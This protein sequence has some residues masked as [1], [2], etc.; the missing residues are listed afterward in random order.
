MAEK[1]KKEYLLNVLR[2]YNIKELEP[3]QYNTLRKKSLDTGSVFFGFKEE[4]EADINIVVHPDNYAQCHHLIES[5]YGRSPIVDDP[6]WKD[7]YNNPKFVPLLC[8]SHNRLYN[9]I[10][11]TDFDAY[12]EYRRASI[13]MME[14]IHD[15]DLEKITELIRR[16]KD[17]RIS[18]FELFKKSDF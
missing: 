8:H 4:D 18:L 1:N 6:E 2:I 11:A 15:P 12:N 3:Y 9:Y 16:N 7:E 10:F 17:I 5:G 14:V 13:R